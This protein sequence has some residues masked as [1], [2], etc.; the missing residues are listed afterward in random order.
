MG[1]ARSEGNS[2]GFVPNSHKH[3]NTY[4]EVGAQISKVL[5]YPE[6]PQEGHFL[7]VFPSSNINRRG[8]YQKARKIPSCGFIVYIS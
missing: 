4:Q 5:E 2:R 7:A 8:K 6:K 3:P 1:Q